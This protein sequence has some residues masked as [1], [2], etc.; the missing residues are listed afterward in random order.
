MISIPETLTVNIN[1]DQEIHDALASLV[2]RPVYFDAFVVDEPDVATVVA[3][4][5]DVGTQVPCVPSTGGL[6][7]SGDSQTG[8]PQTVRSVSVNLSKG[9]HR[10]TKSPFDPLDLPCA[11]IKVAKGTGYYAGLHASGSSEVVVT[12]DGEFTKFTVSGLVH[13]ANNERFRPSLNTDRTG[14]AFEVS[15]AFNPDYGEIPVFSWGDSLEMAD[16]TGSITFAREPHPLFKDRVDALAGDT[17]EPGAA[18][19]ENARELVSDGAIHLIYIPD[20]GHKVK[21]RCTHV[22]NRSEVTGSMNWTRLDD[23][24][25]APYAEGNPSSV[26]NRLPHWDAELGE[27]PGWYAFKGFPVAGEGAGLSASSVKTCTVDV[28]EGDDTVT[29]GVCYYGS[30]GELVSGIAVPPSLYVKAY[31]SGRDMDLYHLTG[32]YESELDGVF[33]EALR[34]PSK[35]CHVVIRGFKTLDDT[36]PWA[37]ERPGL[38]SLAIGGTGQDTIL[39]MSGVSSGVARFPD[40]ARNEAPSFSSVTVEAL[41]AQGLKPAFSVVGPQWV[42]ESNGV[43]IEYDCPTASDVT[44]GSRVSFNRCRLTCAAQQSFPLRGA[45]E[46][47]EFHTCLVET[48]AGSMGYVPTAGFKPGIGTVVGRARLYDIGWRPSAGDSGSQFTYAEAYLPVFPPGNSFRHCTIDVDVGYVYTDS[49]VDKWLCPAAPYVFDVVPMVSC[50]IKVS[51]LGADNVNRFLFPGYNPGVVAPSDWSGLTWGSIASSGKI[52]RCVVSGASLVSEYGIS[53]CVLES[54][55]DLGLGDGYRPVVSGVPAGLSPSANGGFF[56]EDRAG[57]RD[58]TGARPLVQNRGP[59]GARLVPRGCLS[60]Y[61]LNSGI[62]GTIPDRFLRLGLYTY[63]PP[64]WAPAF[65]VAWGYPL[66][67]VAPGAKGVQLEYGGFYALDFFCQNAELPVKCKIGDAPVEGRLDPMSRKITLDL[68]DG[69][70]GDAAVEYMPNQY[71]RCS[72]PWALT[73]AD[74]GYELPDGVSVDEW[75][76]AFAAG[77][78]SPVSF[79]FD[80]TYGHVDADTGLAI[81][82]DYAVHYGKVPGFTSEYCFEPDPGNPDESVQ[83]VC[84]CLV[85][86]TEDILE[87]YRSEL[88]FRVS[89]SLTADF[90]SGGHVTL[91]IESRL[92]GVHEGYGYGDGEQLVVGQECG[93]DEDYYQCLSVYATSLAYVRVSLVTRTG[94]ELASVEIHRG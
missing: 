71:A 58:L 5:P 53:P 54:V 32:I 47:C 39:D 16:D 34:D 84:G 51:P 18:L 94:R 55:D 1:T 80:V 25:D 77:A 67:E 40:L 10:P 87:G 17:S 68:P 20:G 24:F 48:A 57:D 13:T 52:A 42:K 56:D 93:C 85:D 66:P 83:Y 28:K 30:D 43:F 88:G 6:S 72:V 81:R 86:Y 60:A 3:S 33:G 12:Q 4:V 59:S 82:F 7:V 90:G 61:P 14:K 50:G 62:Y 92:E 44:I 15:H 75:L 36:P 9:T 22:S 63:T 74:F 21:V 65:T 27:N 23:S 11:G 64:G 45:A 19:Y 8:Y 38:P 78:V 26:E 2:Q 35:W 49:E 91:S 73:V 41:H 37:P 29:Y 70:R 69:V 31:K 89:E 46:S 76:D 79:R